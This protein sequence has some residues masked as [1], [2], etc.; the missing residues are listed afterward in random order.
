MK[1]IPLYKFNYDTKTEVTSLIPPTCSY[2]PMFR[3][4]A[5]KGCFLTDGVVIRTCADIESD[6][7]K[8]WHELL[9]S[10]YPHLF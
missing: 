4:I 8:K 3:L 10:D 9:K 5:D 6:D 7:F 2:K 1:K